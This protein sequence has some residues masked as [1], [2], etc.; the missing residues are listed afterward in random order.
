MYFERMI[1]YTFTKSTQQNIDVAAVFT[2]LTNQTHCFWSHC[3]LVMVLVYNP[4][5]HYEIFS[6]ASLTA[7]VPSSSSL[8]QQQQQQLPLLQ[9]VPSSSLQPQQATAAGVVT[10]NTAP[11]P[12]NQ[13]KP[14]LCEWAGCYEA[15]RST[16]EALNHAILAHCPEGIEDQPCL[17]QRCDGMKRKRFSLMQHIMDRHCHNQVQTSVTFIHH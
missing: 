16:K 4:L 10:A 13:Q 1:H 8:P 9:T 6:G 3:F 11:P 5:S 7:S 17:W 14:F 12:F 2:S 15:F